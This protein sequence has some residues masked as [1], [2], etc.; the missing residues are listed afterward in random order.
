MVG[1]KTIWTWDLVLG[2]KILG[3]ALC[4]R[5]GTRLESCHLAARDIGCISILRKCRIED[6]RWSL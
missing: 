5:Q 4:V 1:V 2:R 3:V 6:G